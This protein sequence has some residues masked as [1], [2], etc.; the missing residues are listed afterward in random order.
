MSLQRL[1][2]VLCGFEEMTM[3]WDD[4]FRRATGEDCK[5]FEE[6]LNALLNESVSSDTPEAHLVVLRKLQK[7]FEDNERVAWQ[8]GVDTSASY[9]DNPAQRILDMAENGGINTY[10]A[11]NYHN[12]LPS[13]WERC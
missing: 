10:T 7:L 13:S 1:N 4:D 9:H 3:S 6:D 5:K 11:L 2:N 12:W 8:H